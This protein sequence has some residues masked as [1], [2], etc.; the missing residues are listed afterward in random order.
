MDQRIK[1]L[2][3]KRPQDVTEKTG[4]SG[5][6]INTS[7]NAA[8]EVCLLRFMFYL[9]T[10]CTTMLDYSSVDIYPTIQ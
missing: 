3:R 10:Y 2:E 6:E 9:L 8:G 5:H 1:E 7:M 4:M